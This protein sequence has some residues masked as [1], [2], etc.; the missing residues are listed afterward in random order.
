MQTLIRSVFY[1]CGYKNFSTSVDK[2]PDIIIPSPHDFLETN[3]ND[4]KISLPEFIAALSLSCITEGPYSTKSVPLIHSSFVPYFISHV[5]DINLFTLLN[6]G[7][8]IGWTNKLYLSK[9]DWSSKLTMVRNLQKNTYAPRVLK[10][11]EIDA[12][13]IFDGYISYYINNHQIPIYEKDNLFDEHNLPSLDELRLFD[14]GNLLYTSMSKIFYLCRHLK[15]FTYQEDLLYKRLC[16]IGTRKNTIN[17]TEELLSGIKLEHI[18]LIGM[19]PSLCH[20][21]LV[22]TPI[23]DTD[24]IKFAKL[25][26]LRVLKL[27]GITILTGSSFNI[28]FNTEKSDHVSLRILHIHR[29]PSLIDISGISYLEYLEELSITHERNIGRIFKNNNQLYGIDRWYR[30]PYLKKLCLNNI[31]GFN[32]SKTPFENFI[33]HDNNKEKKYSRV[34]DNPISLPSLTDL[35]FSLPHNE[36]ALLYLIKSTTPDSLQKLSIYGPSSVSNETLYEISKL[37]SLQS[38]C[39]SH[40]NFSQCFDNND[41]SYFRYGSHTWNKCANTLVNV[42][43][44]VC[45]YYNDSRTLP[46]CFM[47]FLTPCINIKKLLLYKGGARNIRNY[48]YNYEEAVY[49]LI[50]PPVIKNMKIKLIPGIN[51]DI[52]NLKNLEIS[53]RKGIVAIE[54]IYFKG[55]LD[56]ASHYRKIILNNIST[57]NPV[58]KQIYSDDVCQ[59]LTKEYNNNSVEKEISSPN[60]VCQIYV[61][62]SNDSLIEEDVIDDFPNT[63]ETVIN[64]ESIQST[65]HS[66]SV[67]YVDT[68]ND[69][70]IQPKEKT[71]CG[72]C[73]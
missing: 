53:R 69:M 47:S 7:N 32:S 44:Y 58:E 54:N 31:M 25:C 17:N 43:F 11:L 66:V 16:A 51:E 9:K 8:N 50:I 30:F 33:L 55:M 61:K 70:N 73:W 19:I 42:I 65:E 6:F 60:D 48:I 36:K 27:S 15:K 29:C 56:M 34:F 59:T 72:F 40:I 64:N 52:E 18:Y 12:S 23:R 67:K 37:T 46:F 41:P 1:I 35:S 26:N 49:W 68:D 21:E 14:T 4:N 39:F 5:D 28:L 13:V 62:E 38:V 24:L 45:K 63:S 20:L 22:N 10:K 71:L 57:N 3:I 2:P